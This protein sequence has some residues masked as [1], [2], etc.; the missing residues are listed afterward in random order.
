MAERKST[1]SFTDEE[2]AAMRERNK[3]AKKA[4][5]GSGDGET[6]VL[7]KIAEMTGAD[8][9][10]AETVHALVK[11]NA[12][13]LTPRTYY[14]MPAYARDGAVVLHFKPAAKF[15]TRFATL[16]FS[17]KANLDDGAMWPTEYALTSLTPAD[18]ARLG[19][20]IKQ[21]AG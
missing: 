9:E 15:K 3:E 12:P 10:L 7:A 16:G 20:L 19:A 6:D 21:A 4:A 2:R 11:A 17:D 5:Q 18:K 14:G 1:K 13:E 8:R